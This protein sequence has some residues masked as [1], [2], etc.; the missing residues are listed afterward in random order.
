[1]HRF[2]LLPAPGPRILLCLDGT[3]TLR[4]VPP[5]AASAPA[6]GASASLSPSPASPSP[7]GPSPAS[8]APGGALN[9]TRGDSCFIPFSDG[10]V[11]ATGHARL[12]LAT[13]GLPPA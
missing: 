9:L 3:C 5:A 4:S 11:H 2:T 7:A 12:V 1:M 8:P 13:P 6:S 10:P